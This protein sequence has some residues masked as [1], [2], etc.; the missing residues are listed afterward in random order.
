MTLIVGVH[1]FGYD[2]TNES[3]SPKK[4]YR[5]WQRHVS[6]FS[7]RGFE[8]YS[9]PMGFRPGAILKAWSKGHLHRYAAAWTEAIRA[10]DRLARYLNGVPKKCHLV[11][12]SLGARVVMRAAGQARNVERIL[13][14]SGS[15]STH[16]AYQQAHHTDAEI[17]NVIVPDDDI[18]EWPGSW[19]T[20][21]FGRE[22]IIGYHGFHAP[23]ARNI[24]LK[25]ANT[26]WD[27]YAPEHWPQWTRWLAEGKLD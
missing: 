23:N 22:R 27:A 19:F 9:Y 10:G 16:H 14:L 20:P 5:D 18:L 8:W 25:A 11:A 13:L 15:D 17:L 3:D 6:P 12:H 2:P 1:G 21:K 4:L 7:F 26:H 24:E